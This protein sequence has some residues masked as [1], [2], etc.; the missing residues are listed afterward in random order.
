[1]RRVGLYE[2]KIEPNWTTDVVSCTCKIFADDTKIYGTSSNNGTIQAELLH[3]LDW[4]DLWQ[5]KFNISKCHVIRY[6]NHNEISPYYMDETNIKILAQ[7]T[8]EEM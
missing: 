2:G 4:W 3:L 5:L 8:S 7:T 1:M 6:G